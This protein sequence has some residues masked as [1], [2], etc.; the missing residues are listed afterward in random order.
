MRIAVASGK[1]GTGKTTFSTNLYY[2]LR[3]E[4]RET[5]F[6]D[7]DVEEPNAHIFLNPLFSEKKDV[8]IPVPLI[9]EQ[10]CKRCGDCAK[11]CEFKAL[12]DIEVEI[13]V[14]SELCHG[15][16]LC[17][18]IC[19]SGA[20]REIDRVIGIVQRGK[21]YGGDFI[22][23]TLKIGE[24]LSTPLIRE[25][26][27]YMPEEGITIIDAPPGTSCTVI[28]SIYN[29]DFVLLVTEPTPFGLNDLILAV[30]T[31]RKLGINFGVAVN[32][33]DIGDRKLWQYCKDESIEILIEI[34]HDRRIA[35]VYSKGELLLREI[36]E[37]EDVFHKMFLNI[38]EMSRR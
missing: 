12:V 33:A 8:S 19:H 27:S 30:E 22:N 14:F 29:T 2:L 36:P 4:K 32:R 35:E 24:H 18:F 38:E 28:S 34:P 11:A 7:C 10:R 1:G 20:I 25:V 5:T 16:G 37:Y 13:L 31:V 15:C 17:T 21:A 26:K 6:L 3:R 9:N 23:G